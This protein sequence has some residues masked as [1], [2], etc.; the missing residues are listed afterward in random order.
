MELPANSLSRKVVPPK[1]PSLWNGRSRWLIILLIALIWSA[2][3]AGLFSGKTLVNSG[4]AAQFAAFW[5]AA[6]HPVLTPDFLAITLHATLV[7]FA[8]AVTGTFLS[9][10]IGG[11]FALLASELWWESVWP[12]HQ[13]WQ[14]LPWT[15]IRGLL[16]IPRGIHELIWGLFFL[17]IFGLNPLVA[18]LAIGIP[19]GATVAKIFAEMLD[20]TGKRPYLALLNSGVSPLKAVLYALL[21]LALPD[22]LSYAFYR[23]ECAIRAAAILGVVGAG[24]LGYQIL[25][26]MQTLDYNET[27]TLFYAL[28]LLSG[29]VDAWSAQV[30]QRLG[31]TDIACGNLGDEQGARPTPGRF[32]NVLRGSLVAVLLLVPLSFWY[33]NPTWS[34]LWSERTTILLRDI[35]HQAWPLNLTWADVQALWQLSTATF[36]MS[37]LAAVMAAAGGALLSFPAARSLSQPGVHLR[38]KTDKQV[39]DTTNKSKISQISQITFLFSSA[40]SAPSAV[41]AILFITRTLLL[42]MRAIPA[43]IWALVLLF[44]FFPGMWPGALALAI[45]NMGILGRLMAEVTEN[46][47]KRPSQAIRA[48]GAKSGT[49][50]LYGIVPAVTPRYTAYSLYR[51]ENII[52]ETVVVGLVGAGGL[53]RELSQQLSAFNYRA[54]VA[55]LICLILLTFLV[56]MISTAVRKTLR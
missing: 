36:A 51:W 21:P 30:R 3:Q 28:M 33:L 35:T 1:R 56:D 5:Q 6:F 12:R 23:F 47:D 29:L 52:R 16:A 34:L 20:E 43:P 4:G 38:K 32:D 39:D 40:F 25:L 37:I 42:L 9:L 2:A 53:G 31:R 26:S 10:L 24:G 14:R 11:A 44:I 17:N 15:I 49:V 18:I 45:Y 7:T 19:F 54:V 48:M 13:A 46:Q 55:V 50:F 22:L 27:W 41:Y 8:Y